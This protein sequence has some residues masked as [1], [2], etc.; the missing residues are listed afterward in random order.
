MFEYMV[1]G[2]RQG[3]NKETQ[4]PYHFIELHD[5][6]TLKSGMFSIADGVNTEGLNARDRVQVTFKVQLNAWNNRL[7][8]ETLKKLG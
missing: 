1:V 3:V 8:I 4:K 6:K 7:T 5:P 2:V